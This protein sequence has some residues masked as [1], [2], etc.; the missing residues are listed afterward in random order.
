MQFEVNLSATFYGVIRSVDNL[1]AI[2]KAVHIADVKKK[3]SEL[4]KNLNH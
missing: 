3:D 1:V 4:L 2:L